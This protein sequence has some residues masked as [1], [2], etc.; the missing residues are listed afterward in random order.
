MSGGSTTTVTRR[1]FLATVGTGLAAA[2]GLLRARGIERAQATFDR[3]QRQCA[4][5]EHGGYFE[6]FERD[7]RRCGPASGGGDRK[8]PD[9][10]MHL[11]E[12]FTTLYECTLLTVMIAGTAIGVLSACTGRA[13][14]TTA[15]TEG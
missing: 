8:T 14:G 1:S 2:P 11:M 13:N 4:D 12:A 5:P 9:V 3:I 6:M 7:W 15:A 10:H